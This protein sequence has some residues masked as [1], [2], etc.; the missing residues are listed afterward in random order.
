MMG[1]ESGFQP[2]LFYHQINLDQKVPKHHVLRKIQAQIDF[3]LIY[4]DVRGHYGDNGNVSIPPPIIL[5]MMLLLILYNVR[6]ERELMETIPLRLDWLWVLGYDVDSEVAGQKCIEKGASSLG[7]EW[8]K[9]GQI[10][11][12]YFHGIM[13]SQVNYYQG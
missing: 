2:K 13:I 11:V 5:K 3:D 4:Q 7:R 1:E 12:L 9:R 6:S 8:E 10:F